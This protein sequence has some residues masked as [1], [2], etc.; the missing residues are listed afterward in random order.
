MLLCNL[1]YLYCTGLISVSFLQVSAKGPGKEE[2]AQLESEV[3]DIEPRVQ[4][5]ADLGRTLAQDSGSTQARDILNR[6]ERIRKRWRYVFTETIAQRDHLDNINRPALTEQQQAGPPTSRRSPSAVGEERSNGDQKNVNV[7][8]AWAEEALQALAKNCN[9][10]ELKELRL[11]IKQLQALQT[12][13]PAKKTTLEELLSQL[14]VNSPACQQGR[15]K[16]E[17]IGLLLPKRLSYLMEKSERLVQL[18]EALEADQKWVKDIQERH[19]AVNNNNDDQAALRL[20][21]CEKEYDMNRLMSQFQLLEREV[22]S[23]GLALNPVI[24]S[25]MAD[26]RTRWFQVT[27]E[28]RR[29]TSIA[30]S[31]PPLL[32]ATATSVTV[33]ADMPK[34]NSS[35]SVSSFVSVASLTSPTPSQSSEQWAASPTTASASPMSEE[36]MP[37]VVAGISETTTQLFWARARRLSDWLAGLG[38]PA[39]KINVADTRSVGVEL[40]RLRAVLAQLDAKRQQKDDLFKQF[41][42]HA[43][44]SAGE[45]KLYCDELLSRWHS[46]QQELMARKTELTAMLEHSDN[47]TTKG[48]EVSQWLRKL[49]SVYEGAPVGKTRDILLRQIREVNQ[50][51]RELQQYGH[52]VALLSQV[53]YTPIITAPGLLELNSIVADPDLGS[54]SGDQNHFARSGSD[55]TLLMGFTKKKVGRAY[56]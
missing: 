4:A 40:D 43:D 46:N 39:G 36:V 41:D 11:S 13:L 33:T 5:L 32:T 10:S 54:V 30:S 24:V 53:S 52:H 48:K 55:R 35:H 26:L 16:L 23:S 7:I 51:H 37:V 38:K 3:S 49:E 12:G 42:E 6:H 21:V 28:A 25:E 15:L 29:V 47:V 50:V 17:K 18:A 44:Q 9:V 45:L 1:Q 27:A 2:L 19:H 8:D 56:L 14:G 31:L 34:T 22:L 20:A